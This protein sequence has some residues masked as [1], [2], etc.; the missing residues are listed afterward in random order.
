MTWSAG[1]TAA[2]AYA[3]IAVLL[4]FPLVSR[5]SS[6]VPVDVG[7]PLLSTAILW[8]NAHV[9]PFTQK[10]WDG[11]AFYPASGFMA[12]SDHRLGESLLAA[13]LQWLG[14]SPVT[15]YN[16]TVL[17]TFPLC[18][19]TA[20]WFG[21]VLTG[22]HD[23]AA[24]CGLSFGF[25]PYRVAHLSHLEL[26]GAFGMPAAL[27]ALHRYADT[28]RRRWLVVF[29][30]ALVLQGLAASY[31]LLFFSILLALWLW[32]FLRWRDVGQLL[33]IAVAGAC[34]ALALA[35]IAIGYTRIHS[36]YGLRRHINEIVDLSADVTSLFAASPRLALWGWTAPVAPHPESALF[37][38]LTIAALAL[39]GVIVAWRHP[40]EARNRFVRLQAWLFAVAAAF[41]AVAFCGWWYAPWRFEFAGMK[42]S[43]DAPFKPFTLAVIAIVVSLALTARARGAYARRSVF[44]FYLIATGVLLVCSLGPKPMFLGHQ[45]LYEPPYAWLMRLHAFSAVRVPARFAMPAMLALAAAGAL[46]FNRFP[47]EGS[48][49]R[50]LSMALMAGIIADAWMRE[51]PLPALPDSWP[52]AR[53]HGFAAVLEL[54]IGGTFA[55]LAATYRVT[56]HGH[57]IVNGNSGFEPPHYFTVRTAFEER[58]PTALDGLPGPGPLLIVIGRRDDPDGGL[59]TFLSA[60]PRVSPLAHDEQWMYFAAAPTPAPPPICS[61]D[62]LPI[63]AAISNGEPIDVSVIADDNPDTWWTAP[64]PQRVGDSLVLDFGAPARPCAVFLSMGQFGRSYPRKLIVDTSQDGVE[65]KAVAARRTAGLTMRAALDDPR[66][67]TIPVP[68]ESSSGRFLRLRLDE[69]HETVP[70]TATDVA[71]RSARAQE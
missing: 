6:A 31:Y 71:V 12:L 65:W 69:S 23:A 21:F 47:L 70:W 34:A 41:A 14:C 13:P 58:D 26:L 42:M 32:W 37:P 53:A 17:A 66:R 1:A 25:S 33:A 60:N 15:A 10:W 45:I 68:L 9:L 39:I 22:R 18:A 48:R 30:G 3:T 52:A 35:P 44:A 38:G 2:A 29:G 50:A 27:A 56:G 64:R 28:R 46:A 51:L 24:I 55:D 57:P 61:G 36:Y 62:R 20:H 16:L 8:W 7:D 19:V 54:P 43:S 40:V 67:V 5:L 4:T 59:A 11:F 63:V 49:R